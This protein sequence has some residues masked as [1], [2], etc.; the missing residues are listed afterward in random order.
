MKPRYSIVVIHDEAYPTAPWCAELR[1]G[2][3][4]E[5][6]LRYRA[7]TVGDATAGLL[8]IVTTTRLDEVVDVEALARNVVL[9]HGGDTTTG[10][11]RDFGTWLDDADEIRARGMGVVVSAVVGRVR[12]W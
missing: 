2:V 9:R 12:A 5:W 4:L 1:D 3:R 10:T 11:W 8:R 6:L 7:G